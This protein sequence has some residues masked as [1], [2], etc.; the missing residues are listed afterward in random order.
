MHCSTCN[1]LSYLF[2][3]LARHSVLQFCLLIFLLSYLLSLLALCVS[4]VVVCLYVSLCFCWLVCLW[5]FYTGVAIDFSQAEGKR[6]GLKKD[7]I[8]RSIFRIIIRDVGIQ[9]SSSGSAEPS[10]RNQDQIFPNIKFRVRR[11]RK[12]IKM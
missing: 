11:K 1:C 3:L 10:R 2:I 7:F 12:E 5:L 4:L 9:T 8:C 6:T